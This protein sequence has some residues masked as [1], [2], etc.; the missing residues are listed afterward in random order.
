[1]AG[2]GLQILTDPTAGKPRQNMR[3]TEKDVLKAMRWEE[4]E[5]AAT[6]LLLR[7]HVALLA[8]IRDDLRQ[9]RHQKKAHDQEPK[10]SASSS[11]S[12]S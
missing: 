3:M 5:V 4:Y 7:Y 2:Y 9:L 10:V 8:Q 1:M 11:P 6:R 12:S